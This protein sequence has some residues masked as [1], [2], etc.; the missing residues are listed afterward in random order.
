MKT[1]FSYRTPGYGFY[2]EES[3][4]RYES[5]NLQN[6]LFQKTCNA[7]ADK[8]GEEPVGLELYPM[9]NDHFELG[10]P[11]LIL[12]Y[13][14]V[15]SDEQAQSSMFNEFHDTIRSLYQNTHFAN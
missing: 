8:Y 9:N 11:K 15:L 14:L 5:L 2:T 3:V 12:K 4:L 1:K 10:Q 7:I 13:R 6:N